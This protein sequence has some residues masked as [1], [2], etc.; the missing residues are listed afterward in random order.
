MEAKEIKCKGKAGG[1]GLMANFEGEGCDPMFEITVLNQT[2][3]TSYKNKQLSPIFNETLFFEFVG[4]KL[5]D[6]ETGMM[7]FKLLDHDTFG[8]NNDIGQFCVDI[9]TVY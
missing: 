7:T 8:S 2:K 9:M 6:I 3:T 4:L 1:G 5:A